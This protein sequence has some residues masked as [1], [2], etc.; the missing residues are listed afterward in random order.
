MFVVCVFVV[1]ITAGPSTKLF[2]WGDPLLE[3]VFITAGPSTEDLEE[4]GAHGWK[5]N[6]EFRDYCVFMENTTFQY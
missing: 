5:T 2:A 4:S 1:F 6:S 3:C